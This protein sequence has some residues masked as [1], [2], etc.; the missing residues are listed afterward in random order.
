[1]MDARRNEQ[2]TREGAGGGCWMTRTNW[3]VGLVNMP[4]GQLSRYIPSRVT[5]V[6][7]RS[8]TPSSTDS[9]YRSV[10]GLAGL[11]QWSVSA[12]WADFITRPVW[13]LEICI[14]TYPTRHR[15]RTGWLRWLGLSN[16]RGLFGVRACL[17]VVGHGQALVAQQPG[18]NSSCEV[19]LTAQLQIA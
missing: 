11:V 3:R 16:G 6:G 5:F 18:R 12:C 8:S 2:E 19:D 7:H 15:R 10:G 1:M 14:V 4:L 17:S 13:L 9:V